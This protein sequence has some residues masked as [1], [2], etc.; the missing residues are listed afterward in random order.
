VGSYKLNP[1]MERQALRQIIA[2]PAVLPKVFRHLRPE[3]FDD[4]TVRLMVGAALGYFKKTGA[5]PTSVAVLQEVREGVN[6]GKYPLSRVVECA[7]VLDEASNHAHVDSDYVVGKIMGSERSEAIWAAVE[8]SMKLVTAGKEDDVFAEIEKAHIIGRSSDSPGVDYG[9]NLALRTGKRQRYK[10]PRRWGT[11]IAELDDITRGGLS[12]DN[13]LGLLLAGPKMGK[14]MAMNQIVGHTAACGGSA[15]VYSLEE[16]GEDEWINRID[17]WV[18]E[19]AI[20]ELHGK[21]D[22]VR[23]KVDAFLLKT[24]GCIHVKAMPSGSSVRDLEAYAQQLRVED[25][26]VPDVVV[27]DYPDHMVAKDPSKFEKR[28]EELNAI[29]VE[30]RGMLRKL[31]CVGWAPS[32]IKADALEKK[33]P[34]LNDIAGAFAKAFTADLIIAL[35][36]TAEEKADNMVRFGV[37]ASRF[38]PDGIATQQLPS[39]Y[40]MGMVVLRSHLN[41]PAE[42]PF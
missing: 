4:P 38:S 25:G 1:D 20:D 13:P 15:L 8:K 23:A 31:G 10:A 37:L 2:D 28:H 11:G 18:S 14:S 27:V 36:R 42:N 7:D 34:N 6:S 3:G 17:A 9:K 33:Q 35:M 26:F 19:T 22:D 39:A 41:T 30:L 16:M 12:T 29:L 5:A 40:G 24:G 21:A 32:Q